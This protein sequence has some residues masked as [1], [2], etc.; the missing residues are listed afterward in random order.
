M[1]G[2]KAKK[3][4]GVAN[5]GMAC[6]DRIENVRNYGVIS[7]IATAESQIPVRVDEFVDPIGRVSDGA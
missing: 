3:P 5:T 4:R 6:V 7:L 1:C 2:G